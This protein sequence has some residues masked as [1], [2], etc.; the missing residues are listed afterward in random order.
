[1]TAICTPHSKR[2]A[3]FTEVV[4]LPRAENVLVRGQVRINSPD[5]TM[6]SEW[7]LWRALSMI[8][9]V[10]HVP[11]C[12][13]CST[14]GSWRQ[15]NLFRYCTSV[16][17]QQSLS[18]LLLQK[19]LRMM[20]FRKSGVKDGQR[21]WLRPSLMLLLTVN[22]FHSN[23][24]PVQIIEGP[25]RWMSNRLTLRPMKWSNCSHHKSSQICAICALWA[26]EHC[27]V[28]QNWSCPVEFG[29]YCVPCLDPW[30]NFCRG[31]M[32]AVRI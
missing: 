30:P 8:H 28:Q 3:T 21:D 5:A 29:V 22:S 24:S 14:I 7:R 27:F 31:S 23:H 25:T 13:P 6:Q 9:D 26:K 32:V 16:S 17:W 20:A 15:R 18:T 19:A 1:M 4:L 2:D 12:A 10:P 11:Q